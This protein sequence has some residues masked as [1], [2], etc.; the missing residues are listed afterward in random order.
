V[1]DRIK[2]GPD[3]SPPSDGAHA[4]RKKEQEMKGHCLLRKER[5]SVL[6]FA[7]VLLPVLFLGF[8]AL[9]V[10]LA[11][12]S[13]VKGQ[14]QRA[15]DAAALAGVSGLPIGPAEARVRAHAYAAKNEVNGAPTPLL[16]QEIEVGR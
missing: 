5:G 1:D 15:A 10:D 9:S 6:L 3:L 11:Y 2:T 14:L 8:A 4:P 16:D 7:I 12:V 13:A